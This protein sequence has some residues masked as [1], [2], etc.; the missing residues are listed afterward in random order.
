MR[1]STLR[2]VMATMAALIAGCSPLRKHL[3]ETP[4]NIVTTDRQES[5]PRARAVHPAAALGARAAR[6]VGGLGVDEPAGRYRTQ[7][8]LSSEFH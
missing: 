7:S 8:W 4:L 3:T 6:R 5:W 2:T 1:S